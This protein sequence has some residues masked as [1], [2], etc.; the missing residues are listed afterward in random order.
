M[1]ESCGT[2]VTKNAN[3]LVIESRGLNCVQEM[4]LGS[5]KHKMIKEAKCP[6][7]IIK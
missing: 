1:V 6:V 7:T 4:M 2:Q 5:V 3:H